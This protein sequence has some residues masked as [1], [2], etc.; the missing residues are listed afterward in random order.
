MLMDEVKIREICEKMKNSVS[1][2]PNGIYTISQPLH[3][4]RLVRLR[5]D[6]G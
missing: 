4:R 3:K 1:H 2:G 6:K 5:I